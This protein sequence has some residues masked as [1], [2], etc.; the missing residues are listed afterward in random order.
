LIR[1]SLA[2]LG[3]SRKAKSNIEA[4]DFVFGEI[5]KPAKMNM[6]SAIDTEANLT[7]KV[8]ANIAASLDISISP[9]ETKFKLIDESLVYRRNKVAH[10][11][12]LDLSPLDFEALADEVLQMMRSYKA[13]IENAASLQSY[14][15]PSQPAVQAAPVPA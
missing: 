8:F 5:D 2:H 10:G 13:D 12:Y 1:P 3:D 14:K 15:R 7:S 6:S 4:L 11:V 9:Y